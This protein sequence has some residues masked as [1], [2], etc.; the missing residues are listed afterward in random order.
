[1]LDDV[2]N[3]DSGLLGSPNVDNPCWTTS[4]SVFMAGSSHIVFSLW[5]PRYS[6]GSLQQPPR[7]CGSPIKS[8]F[9][10]ASHT[11]M[12][13]LS[14]GS[15]LCPFLAP[16]KASPTQALKRECYWVIQG[17]DCP[18]RAYLSPFSILE[19]LFLQSSWTPGP[20]NE[21]ASFQPHAHT[22]GML[23]RGRSLVESLYEREHKDS[24]LSKI[25][26]Y[27]IYRQ[28]WGTWS[29]DENII[30]ES[31]LFWAKDSF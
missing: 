15:M 31:I 9:E 11:A 24:A 2:I 14:Q 12:I 18:C 13:T 5:D 28:K 26:V 10:K 6:P 3:P 16:S 1:M 19:L 23:D 27:W 30:E 17:K 4:G 21:A 20:N 29:F 8:L 22:L 25:P 7:Q